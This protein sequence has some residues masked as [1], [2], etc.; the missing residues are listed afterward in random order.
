MRNCSIVAVIIIALACVIVP[1]QQ[2]VAEEVL[3]GTNNDGLFLLQTEAPYTGFKIVTYPPDVHIETIASNASG[4]LYGMD[5]GSRLF[6]ISPETESVTEIGDLG[7]HMSGIAFDNSGVFWGVHGDHVYTIDIG[8]LSVQHVG[9][10]PT[11][12]TGFLSLAFDSSGTLWGVDDYRLKTID[13]T[14]WVAT[15]V[16][17]FNPNHPKGISFNAANDLWL[18]M[19]A[20]L[21]QVQTEPP[22]DVIGNDINGY[23]GGMLDITFVPEPSTALLLA[24][25]C[26]LALRR[27]RQQT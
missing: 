17:N 18:V 14:T 20:Y 16:I 22:Y 7:T 23:A 12:D 11:F 27:R 24:T 2:A 10:M 8:S 9:T 5:N 1:A 15:E 26:V 25:A 13:Q 3:Y 6:S 21:Y 4:D 19:G